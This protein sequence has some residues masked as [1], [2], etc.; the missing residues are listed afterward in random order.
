MVATIERAVGL[1]AAMAD[2]EALAELG[3]LV[4]DE[5]SGQKKKI[6][7]LFWNRSACQ[8]HF[9]GEAARGHRLEILITTLMEARDCNAKCWVILNERF[10]L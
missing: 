10:F 2:E 8:V 9:V 3:L 7:A 6:T 4:V 1:I 5:V